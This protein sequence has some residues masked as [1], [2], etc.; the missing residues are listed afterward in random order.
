[1]RTGDAGTELIFNIKDKD[2]KLVDLTNLLK[3]EMIYRGYKVTIVK[4]CIVILPKT[5]GKV[6]YVVESGDFPR[7]YKYNTQI[8]LTF[9]D[10]NVF[11]SDNV[12]IIVGGVIG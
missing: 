9:I 11:Y 3:A 2:N 10:G 12:S 5:S 8:K 1:M 6:K 4:E 7:E